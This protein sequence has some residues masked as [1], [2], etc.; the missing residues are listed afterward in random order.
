MASAFINIE[1]YFIRMSNEHPALLQQVLMQV[2]ES[3]EVEQ[4]AYHFDFLEQ[5]KFDHQDWDK[6]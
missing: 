1:Y 2:V 4:Y 3:E 6:L 5:R